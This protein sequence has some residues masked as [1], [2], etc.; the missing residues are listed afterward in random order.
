MTELIYNNDFEIPGGSPMEPAD[1]WVASE[2]NEVFRIDTTIVGSPVPTG[3]SGNQ[4]VL[5]V[6]SPG[7]GNSEVQQFS[8]PVIPGNNYTLNLNGYFEGAWEELFI[9]ISGTVEQFLPGDV[10]TGTWIPISVPFVATSAQTLTITLYGEGASFFIDGPSALAPL[11]CY[12]G[13]SKVLVQNIADNL[14]AEIPAKD[15]DANQHLVFDTAANTFIPIVANKMTGPTKEYAKIP[16]DSLGPNM[17]SEDFFLTKG[18]YI[19]I[20]GKEVKAKNIKTAVIEDAPNNEF[21][22]SIITDPRTTI[23]VNGLP[24]FTFSPDNWAKY[25]N[26]KMKPDITVSE[27]QTNDESREREL[28]R[29]EEQTSELSGDV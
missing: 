26:E 17:P 2:I 20:N 21:V 25:V 24:T 19:W 28:V 12:S 11:I 22:Y 3:P 29:T 6:F 4:Y 7:A 23:Q 13:I 14:I 8:I 27:R 16:K 5:Q 15:V 10:P 18:H 9:S 1:G